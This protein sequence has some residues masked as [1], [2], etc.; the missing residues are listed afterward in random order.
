M[1]DTD[2]E[3]R[4]R[5]AFRPLAAEVAPPTLRQDVLAVPAR[6][7][8][9]LRLRRPQP[10]L[11]GLLA[12]AIVAGGLIGGGLIGNGLLAN[13]L[14][15][16]DA[17][18]TDVATP[19]PSAPA[20]V[21]VLPQNGLIAV[22]SAGHLALVE[23]DGS[24]WRTLTDDGLYRFD[25]GWSPD[26]RKLA[27]REGICAGDGRC[28][29]KLQPYSVGVMDADGSN[30]VIVATGLEWPNG[31]E[32]TPDGRLTIDG[33]TIAV[34]SVGTTAVVEHRP[35]IWSDDARWF[36]GNWEDGVHVQ[37]ADGSADALVATDG[38]AAP[39]AFLRDDSGI[40][41]V[42]QSCC[43]P[44]HW[45]SFVVDLAGGNERPVPAVPSGAIFESWSPDRSLVAYD[46]RSGSG[47]HVTHAWTLA[48][49]DGEYTITM[50]LGF[51]S[52]S[53]DGTRF[54]Q[55]D[56][57]AEPPRLLVAD[58][59]GRTA[60]VAIAGVDGSGVSWQPLP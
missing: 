1:T 11:L 40:V 14:P 56:R 35:G 28:P 33:G 39:A 19:A 21:A 2:L 27:F 7:P 51:L 20:G 8:R 37:H 38:V 42:L 9:V 46:L 13:P 34:A 55:V 29:D 36:A 60:T 50:P 47:I 30:Q 53:P 26:G 24:G 52:W 49:V 6:S 12:A 4:L 25:P 57:S 16:T 45:G 32:W 22:G 44:D 23:P 31:Y 15:T 54:L 5:A 48:R 43:S 58:P 10:R 18:A 59:T 17:T 41:I 3:S